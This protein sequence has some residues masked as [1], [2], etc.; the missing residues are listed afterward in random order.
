[1][2]NITKIQVDRHQIQQIITNLILNSIDAMDE[3]GSLTIKTFQ[4]NGNRIKISITDSG[5]GIAK[6][7]MSKIFQP[8]YSTKESGTGMGL[9]ICR[10]IINNHQGEIFVDS[11][12]GMGTTFTILIPS[13]QKNNQN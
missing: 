13:R 5:I 11:E 2:E 1:M 8:F 7:E 4:A 6:E 10:S 12:L 9:A 3:K